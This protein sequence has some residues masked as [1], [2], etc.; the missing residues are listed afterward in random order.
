MKNARQS[1]S[2]D[3]GQ[4]LKATEAYTIRRQRSDHRQPKLRL[5]IRIPWPSTLP[6]LMLLHAD[7]FKPTPAKPGRC[8][9]RNPRMAFEGSMRG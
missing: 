1:A 4:R 7:E 9:C 6:H 3:T 2:I 8:G 5:G